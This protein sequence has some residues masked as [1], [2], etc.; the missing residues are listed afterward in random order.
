[1]SVDLNSTRNSPRE[2]R[3]V[4]TTPLITVALLVGSCDCGSSASGL[5]FS[6]CQGCIHTCI[7]CMFSLL[8]LSFTIIPLI[9]LSLSLPSRLV[10]IPVSTPRVSVASD[11]PPA[12][13]PPP[14]RSPSR[15]PREEHG[16]AGEAPRGNPPSLSLSLSPSP[17]SLVFS[18]WLIDRVIHGRGVNASRPF[19]FRRYSSFR[20]LINL[21][22]AA[23]LS[24][25][26][27]QRGVYYTGEDSLLRVTT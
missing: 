8:F 11:P 25:R 2:V 6:A 14:P 15:R 17:S 23:R 24:A 9:S 19:N 26:A 5:T 4:N 1:V 22:S 20:V 27:V 21:P 18:E 3:Y 13:P 12:F 16:K 7:P 10:S